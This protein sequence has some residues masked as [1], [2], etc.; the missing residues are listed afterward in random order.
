MLNVQ[1][2]LMSGKSYHD[3]IAEFAIRVTLNETDSTIIL[4]YNQCES[5]RFHDISDECRGLVVDVNGN[6]VARA[7]RRFYNLEERNG[8]HNF[9]WEGSTATDKVDGSLI[10]IYYYNGW[11][12]NTRGSFGRGTVCPGLE[13]TW[14]SLVRSCINVEGLN[15]D[16]TYVAELCSPYNKVVVNYPETTVYLLSV[17]QGE[18]ELPFD[19]AVELAEDKGFEIP[20][21]HIFPSVEDAKAFIT[22]QANVFG[23]GWEGIVLRDKNDNR[24]KV[25][26][27]LYVS[28]HHLKGNGNLFLEKNLIPLI[29]AGEAEETIAYFPEA[30]P[31]IQK[32]IR[33][34]DELKTKLDNFWFCWHDEASQKKFALAA[35]KDL[36]RY[37][38][39]VFTARKFGVS[40]LSLLDT[41]TVIRLF[42]Y[43]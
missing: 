8:E 29:I 32:L 12:I 41:D 24:I 20:P 33:Q 16:Y 36:G 40:P 11:R 25:K 37:S 43:A 15:P 28:L 2:Y 3:L 30:G 31:K 17:F 10:L 7:F 13:H 39:V 38:S 4:N 19:E 23:G 35:Q 1:K 6:L 21:V 27:P 5:P 9:V 26:N 14:E 22:E 34:I 42:N 18:N